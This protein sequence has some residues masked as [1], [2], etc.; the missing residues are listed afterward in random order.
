MSWQSSKQKEMPTPSGSGC[1][2]GGGFAAFNCKLR[3]EIRLVLEQMSSRFSD[4][5]S[6]LNSQLYEGDSQD[7]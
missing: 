5:L 6:E 3:A 7:P 2:C 1:I 4:D